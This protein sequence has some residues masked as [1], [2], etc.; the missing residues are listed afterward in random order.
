MEG[1]RE[2]MQWLKAHHVGM[3]ILAILLAVALWAF[4]IATDNPE[5]TM[6]YDG[7]GVQLIGGATIR[8]NNNLI[9]TEISNPQVTVRLRGSFTRLGEVEDS[10]IIVRADVSRFTEPGTYLVDYD[11]SV[12]NGLT[13]DGKNPEK[14]RLTIDQY[15]EKELEVRAVYDG[16]FEDSL[17]VGSAVIT[18]EKVRVSGIASVLDNAQYAIVMVDA[19]ALTESFE[20]D[21][22]FF[23]AD[24]DDKPLDSE[25]T[26]YAQSL[27]HVEIPVYMT[28]DIPLEVEK[29]GNS[30]IPPE[31]MI[32]N[33]SMDEVRIHGEAQIIRE[34]ESLMLGSIDVSTFLSTATETYTLELPEGVEIVGSP[35]NSIIAQVTLDGI[36]SAQ[37]SLDK[38]DIEFEN[39]PE[40]IEVT[41][42]TLNVVITVRGR[43]D[44]IRDL[45]AEDFHASVDIS[46]RA[47]LVGRQMSPLKIECL[48]EGVELWGNYNV[49]LTTQ[50]AR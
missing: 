45:R 50:E 35:I 17:D 20:G 8:S 49:V 19:A 38:D 34:I 26:S 42:E 14:L 5:R 27:V 9:V 4:A 10:N 2:M 24:G 37:I 7:I 16:Q 25:Y 48:R 23:V 18:P 30:I 11:V 21:L 41:N 32:V 46:E 40:G 36:E 29:I 13:V 33:L 12:P 47:S 31:N 1:E 15:V 6:D 43:T 3:K 28:K 22:D 39:V 44:D